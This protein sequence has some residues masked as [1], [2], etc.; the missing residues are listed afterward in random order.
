MTVIVRKTAGTGGLVL[1]AAVKEQAI[2][3]HVHQDLTWFRL[4]LA[5]DGQHDTIIRYKPG[6]STLKLDRTHSGLP[7]DI[8]GPG[9]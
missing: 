9:V 8:V 1:P 2:L 4:H 3:F 6:E 5:K 7:R